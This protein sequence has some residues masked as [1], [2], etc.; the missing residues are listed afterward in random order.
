[1]YTPEYIIPVRIPS[2]ESPSILYQ[3]CV[4]VLIVYLIFYKYEVYM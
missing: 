1:M 3:V 2:E 4:L